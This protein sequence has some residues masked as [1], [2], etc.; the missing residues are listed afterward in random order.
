MIVRPAQDT[1]GNK[2]WQLIKQPDHARLSADIAEHWGK[3]PFQELK[4]YYTVFQAI[5]RH[6]DGWQGWELQPDLDQETGNPLSF[7]DTPFSDSNQLW[8]KSID[9]VK[10]LGPLAQYLVASHFYLLREQSE[11]ADSPEG[12]AFLM[13][14]NLKRNPWLN[15]WLASSEEN[16]L[17]VAEMALKQLRFF[18]WIS[19]WFCMAE[20]TESYTF[21]E[22][23]SG[24]PLVI[25]PLSETLYQADPWPW[26]NNEIEFQIPAWQ[27]P[28]K[29]YPSK[30]EMNQEPGIEIMLSWKLKKA[31]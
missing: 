14:T 8:R 21:Q 12:R 17:E 26:T 29:K 27:I 7:M 4:P 9:S 16:T 1:E 20:R 23:P 15:E 13:E 2:V 30:R 28:D 22:T 5:E 10:N 31:K 6:D 11:S 3:P 19:L 25:T 24:T 18:D